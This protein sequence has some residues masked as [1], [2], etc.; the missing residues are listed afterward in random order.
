MGVPV[1]S[2]FESLQLGSAN[3]GMPGAWPRIL[4]RPTRPAAHAS[5][6]A[7]AQRR[8]TIVIID[9]APC[10]VRLMQELAS[11]ADNC[12]TIGFSDPG[13]ALGWCMRGEPDLIIVGFPTRGLDGIEVTR[14]LRRTP[15]T[16]DVPVLMVTAAHE[17]G[18]RHRALEGGV[19]DFLT[20][21]L[22]R[23]EFA[24]RLKSMLALR[25]SHLALADRTEYLAAEVRRAMAEVHERERETIFRLARAA[26]FRDPG[27]GSHILRMASYAQLI[28]VTL[29]LPDNDQEMIL[30][31]APMHDVGKLGSPD[32]ILL[33]PGPLTATE[34]ELMKRHSAMGYEILRDST[35]P[36]LQMAAQIALSHHERF[37]GGG[38]PR[39]LAGE[40]IPLPGRMVAVADVFDALTSDRP[41]KWAW[42]PD[43]AAEFLQQGRAK[44]FDPDC[45]DAFLSAWA[46]VTAIRDRYHDEAPVSW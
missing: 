30:Q 11:R 10:T 42:P 18:V 23:L 8:M 4:A 6:P 35:S 38:Y 9:D 16:S 22:E 1:N 39:G 43:R 31:A 13:E 12:E 44:H 21:P 33:K 14:H 3:R 27:T 26:E 37:D 20:K 15:S 34:Y 40:A 5:K 17:T 28:A 25:R 19:T 24:S 41:Y 36:V 2:S 32:Q 46:A 7:S 45:V 29:G